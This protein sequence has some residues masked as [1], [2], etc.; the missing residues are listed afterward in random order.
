MPLF[1]TKFDSAKQEWNT[2][3]C[4]FNQLRREFDFTI[5]LA[6]DATNAKC[7]AY[8]TAEEDAL[9]RAEWHGVCW[10][11]PPYGSQTSRLSKWVQKAFLEA[12]TK[13]DCTVVMLLPAR[14]NT[15]WW[16]EFCMRA[17]EIRFIR[18]RPKFGDSCHGLPQPL[19]IVVF[20]P[21]LGKTQMSSFVLEK[22]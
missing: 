16:H 4:L 3:P 17:A 1:A 15:E 6:A 20:R 5:D 10:L 22:G 19:A 7:N 21:H 8:F 11:N 14:T 2:P 13:S 9:S 12:Q 18:G